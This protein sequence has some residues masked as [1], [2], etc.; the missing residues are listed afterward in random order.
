MARHSFLR[1]VSVAGLVAPIALVGCGGDDEHE[2]PCEVGTSTGCMDG[3]VCEE[4]EGAEEPACFAPVHVEGRVF[5][6]SD[7]GPI[8]GARV[9]ALDVNGF[10]R[11]GVVFSNVMGQYSLPISVKRNADGAPLMD[12]ITLRVAASGYQPFPEAPRTALPIDLG[13]AADGEGHLTVQNAATDVALIPLPGD[14]SGLGTISGR[15]DWDAPGGVLVTATQGDTAVSTS[16]TDHDGTFRLYNVP[17]G[18]TV[19]DGFRSGLSVEEQNVEST[20]NVT[21]VVLAAT[22][23]GLATVT[24]SVNIVNAPGGSMTSVILGVESTFIE[25]AA[26][27][28]APA[29]LR[30]ENVTGAFTIEGVPPGRYVVLA[31]FENDNLVRDP[32]PNIGGTQIV[33]IVVP[34]GGGT[35]TL[36][37]SFKVTEALEVFSPGA[38]GVESIATAQPTF[39]WAD[40]SSEDG[41]LIDV[42]DAFGELVHMDQ[43]AGV[44]GSDSV[45]YTWADAALEPGM[46]YQFRAFSF[47][48]DVTGLI[49]AT[50]DLRG[51]FIYEP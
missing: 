32:D 43:I 41:Y 11:S 5:D 15:V 35:V 37:E 28:E 40:D 20:G 16:I 12:A 3:L 4:V 34:E 45:T 42:Y 19:V 31:A 17:N 6:S 1:F 29:G 9:V 33:H 26:R 8:E 23:E 38:D 18:A 46:V 25:N 7:D 30:A 24:G 50:E 47:R 22:D 44:S 21:D 39:E 14:T 13:T 2:G 27:A 36:E 51:V 49:S 10:A 48:R